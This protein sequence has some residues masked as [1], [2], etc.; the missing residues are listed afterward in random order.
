MV[1]NTLVELKNNSFSIIS[2]EYVKEFF[3]EREVLGNALEKLGEA[4]EKRKNFLERNSITATEG[5]YL[6]EKIKYTA[7]E[8]SMLATSSRVVLCSMLVKQSF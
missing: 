8:F 2:T 3:M 7:E 4:W 5:E 1:Y 6:K